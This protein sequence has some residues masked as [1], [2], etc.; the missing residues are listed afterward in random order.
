MVSS[1]D[2]TGPEP[3]RFTVP[4]AVVEA[5]RAAEQEIIDEM[6]R[7][8]MVQVPEYARGRDSVYGTTI[9]LS[10]QQVLC[11]FLD[12]VT[13]DA[14]G[15]TQI[16][17]V[18]HRIG[19]GEAHFGRSLDALQ[20]AMHVGVEVMWRRLARLG[21]QFGVDEREL[22]RLAGALLTHFRGTSGAAAEGYAEMQARQANHVQRHR[23]HLAELL[24]G[25]PPVCRSALEK[26]AAA[27]HWALPETI[28]V[29]VLPQQADDLEGLE[30]PLDILV[31]PHRRPPCLV[32]PD[33]E[34][35]GRLRLVD[36][37]LRGQAAVVGLTLPLADAAKSLRW[38]CDAA[39][40]ARRG[41]L[42]GDDVVH[43]ADHMST[44]VLFKNEDLIDTLV[45]V[46]LAPLERVAQPQRDR[47]AETLLA[48]LQTEGD[49]SEVAA[50]LHVHP[51]TVRYRIRQL[52]DLFGDQLSDPD[53]HLELELALWARQLR[54]QR[55]AP[56]LSAPADEP[57][58]VITV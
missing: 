18:F 16:A 12:G 53:V 57:S 10:S 9:L 37:A 41:L 25:E 55:Q 38:A 56:R 30:L 39:V 22:C 31:H 3:I 28:A 19:Y 11:D 15:Q 5:F 51:Q 24:L 8:I 46:R 33:P 26:A 49:A 6:A 54:I 27:A 14:E 4:P 43:C 35:A 13:G 42:G 40:L 36:R 44:L 20:A 52:H 34:R 29:V 32:V 45:A 7:E 58:P 1:T 47:L 21:I 50:G 17:E 2:V 48:W 23:Q